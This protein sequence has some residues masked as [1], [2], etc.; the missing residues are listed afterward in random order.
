MPTAR[1]ELEIALVQASPDAVIVVDAA[2]RIEM[3]NPAVESLFGWAPEELIGQPVELLLPEELRDLHRRHRAGYAARPVAR[4]MG[5]GLDLH[6]RRRDGTSFPVDVG[7]APLTAGG[8]IRVGAFVRDA[9]DR[10]RGEDLL[11]YVNEISRELLAGEDTADTLRLTANRAR[12]LVEAEAAWIVVPRGSSLTVAAADGTGA[13]VLVG[14]NVP[15]GTS[16]SAKVMRSGR[17]LAIGEMAADPAVIAE[18]RPLGLGPGLYLP[19]AA[20]SRSLGTLVVARAA[21]RPP[22]GPSEA[23]AL[24]VFASA[25]A[26]VLSLGQAREELEAL[27]LVSEHERIARD[28]H[29]TVIQRLFA[30]GMSLQG[31]QRL[32]DGVVAERIA[33]A[34]GAIDDVIREI[35]ETIFDLSQPAAGGPEIRRKLRD[36]VR[37]AG[38]QLGFAPRVGFRGPVEAAIDDRLVPDLLSVVREALSNVARHAHA[39]AVEVVL[40]AQDSSV[41]LTVADNG[42]G[43]PDGPSAGHGIANLQARASKLGGELRLDRRHP[44]GTLLQWRVPSRSD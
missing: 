9:T 14:A 12:V 24:A 23:E 41:L 40:E 26:I 19:M 27:R 39:T 1:P 44:S 38:Q 16:L 28:L 6:G 17:P 32:A 4:A 31:L 3:A 35:R 2:G 18:A 33:A 36:V 21:S 15:A 29:D 22:F 20:E 13:E 34:V 37:E 10:R 25:A 5:S 42:V 11:R 8:A 43:I 30:L 7:L